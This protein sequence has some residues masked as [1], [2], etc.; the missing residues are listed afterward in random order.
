VSTLGD[1]IR[2]VAFPLLAASLTRDPRA[3]AVVAAAGFL[4]WPL[5]GLVGGAVVD[6]VDRKWLM[7]MTD[8]GRA[9]LVGGFAIAV[10]AECG[11]VAALAA[12]SFVLGV[13]ETLFDNAASAIL[14]MLV[15]GQGTERANSWL[16]STQTIMS[17]L[18]GPPV[19]SV[20]FGVSA[21]VPLVVDAGTFAAAAVLVAGIAGGFSAR[22][23]SA[24]TTVRQDITEGLRWL[25]SHHLLRTL[26]LQLAVLN[27]AFAA[28]EA[29]LVL[30]ALEV[31]HVGSLGYSLLLAVVAVGGVFGAVAG[32]ALGRTTGLT[33]VVLVSGASEAVALALT[34]LTSTVAVTAPALAVVG[35]GSMAWNV[36]TV[37]LR[38]A[39]VPPEL[40][41][42]VTSSYRVV[43]LGA[44]PVGAALAGVLAK[45]HG[46]HAP[47]LIS[48]VLVAVSTLVCLPAVRRADHSA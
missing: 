19:G 17:T 37:S 40:L 41:G 28:G 30:Y 31:L 46:L 26:C 45:A 11:S 18:I 29:V 43:A 23:T 14:P 2:Y 8:A 9:V 1:G 7:W 42:R 16:M 13:A 44:I 39:V 6:R 22:T 35:F 20:L 48:G 3:V 33:G 47:Y 12:V 36:V 21:A 27:L 15:P 25:W 4:P 32:P 38:Q 10:A 34:G 24:R 5:F